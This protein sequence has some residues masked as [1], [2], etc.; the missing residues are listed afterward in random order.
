M[1][2]RVITYIVFFFVAIFSIGSFYAFDQKE[3][4]VSEVLEEP[5]PPLVQ[6]ELA[7]KIKKYQGTILAKCRKKALEAAESY[8][9]SLV[10]EE[11]KLQANDTI[12]FPAKPIRPILQEQIILNDS[13]AIAPIIK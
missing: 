5:I 8:I 12:K 3:D 7:L 4:E 2:I 1:K 11:L 6:K 10:S 9:D 13:T